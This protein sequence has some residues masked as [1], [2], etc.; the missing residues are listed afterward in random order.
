MIYPGTSPMVGTNDPNSLEQRKQQ[1]LRQ[2]TTGGGIR[3]NLSFGGSMG[4]APGR[5]PA[6]SFNPFFAAQQAMFGVNNQGQAGNAAVSGHPFFGSGIPTQNVGANVQQAAS[7]QTGQA[8]GSAGIGGV[9][10]SP[11]AAPGGVTIDAGA[12]ARAAHPAGAGLQLFG[13]HYSN[14]QFTPDQPPP[15]APA[16][17][18][19]TGVQLNPLLY[20][21]FLP[22][23]GIAPLL[24]RVVSA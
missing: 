22:N 17:P 16:P 23:A 18:P 20:Q 13:G 14:G 15:P 4:D 8:A 5:A 9:A 12:A 11:A 21:G 7:A 3:N 10:G 24:G 19:S 1:L 6:L 2:L